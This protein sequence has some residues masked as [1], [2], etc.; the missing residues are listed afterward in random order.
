MSASLT[1]ILECIVG[2]I[3]AEENFVSDDELLVASL[4]FTNALEDAIHTAHTFVALGNNCTVQHHFLIQQLETT[5]L[6]PGKGKGKAG[7]DDDD[8][9]CTN[10]FHVTTAGPGLLM[11]TVWMLASFVLVFYDHLFCTTTTTTVH[12]LSPI[13][14]EIYS[15]THSLT[16]Q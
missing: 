5:A 7:E 6:L 8:S 11:C 15:C 3:S 1:E 9:M 13:Y 2:L 14:I 12:L 10:L 16:N 4:S